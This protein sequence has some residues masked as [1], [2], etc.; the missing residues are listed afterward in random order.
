MKR[1][2]K[3]GEQVYST[4]AYFKWDANSAEFAFDGFDSDEDIY[5]DGLL[6]EDRHCPYVEEEE[7]DD[8][9]IAG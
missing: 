9:D 3:D 6:V 8:E 7:A 2:L 5:C 1:F 4:G